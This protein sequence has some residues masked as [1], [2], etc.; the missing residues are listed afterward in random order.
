MQ[1][2][3]YYDSVDLVGEVLEGY[4]KYG[5]GAKEFMRLASAIQNL[6]HPAPGNYPDVTRGYY[7]QYFEVATTIALKEGICTKDGQL[8]QSAPLTLVMLTLNPT[9]QALAK[10]YGTSHTTIMHYR[11]TVLAKAARNAEYRERFISALR[12]AFTWVM[13]NPPQVYG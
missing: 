4:A 6:L 5:T 1:N 10:A 9:Q 12:T 11:A 8:N 3:S 2:P 13:D 7:S